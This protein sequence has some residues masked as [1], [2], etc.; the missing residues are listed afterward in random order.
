M[1]VFLTFLGP[2]VLMTI[3]K[4]ILAVGECAAVCTMITCKSYLVHKVRSWFDGL[5]AAVLIGIDRYTFTGIELLQK[6][7]MVF[8]QD[9]PMLIV[10]LFILLG[11]LQCK[12]LL[13]ESSAF[14]SSLL[15]TL[16]NLFTF[17]V[18]KIF[19]TKATEEHFVMQCLEG[20]T[21][22]VTWLPHIYKMRQTKTCA[23]HLNFGNL[24]TR[25]PAVTNLFGYYFAVDF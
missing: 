23:L 13:E 9:I 19:E 4:I 21:A 7:S 16:L 8:F 15:T 24:V 6:N 22:N 2:T 3:S 25:I 17:I 20:M 12:E 1:M 5:G 11:V 14:Y 10:Q 18:T